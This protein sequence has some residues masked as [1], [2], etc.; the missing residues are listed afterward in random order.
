[1]KIPPFCGGGQ[2][3]AV[4]NWKFLSIDTT[5]TCV[6]PTANKFGFSLQAKAFTESSKSFF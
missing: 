3:I 2:L 4:D 1:M 6:V 5:F